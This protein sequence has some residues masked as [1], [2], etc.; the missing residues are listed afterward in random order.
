MRTLFTQMLR[1]RQL[2][3]RQ[4]QWV[5]V[6]I[7]NNAR[8]HK[9]EDYSPITL[10]NTVYK[11]L[12]RLISAGVRPILAELLH[13]SQY[14]YVPGNTIFDAVATVR[15]AIAYAESTRRPFYWVS[16]DFKQVF[17]RISHTYLPTVL[18]SYGFDSGFI[19]Y[20]RMVY[21][22]ATS[23]IQVKGHISAPIPTQCGVRQGCPLSMIIFV[24]CLKPSLYYL[25]E[26][27]R[28]FAHMG[29]NG[30]PRWSCTPMMSPSW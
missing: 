8:P 11:I 7:P 22:N 5:L 30:R 6:C 9:R 17:D 13:P 4:K 16:L 29:R 25:D 15:D 23:V 26:R 24:L 1:D 18:R 19:E 3:E 21:G 28:D 10:L 14:C 12:V 20:I 27:L 2:S